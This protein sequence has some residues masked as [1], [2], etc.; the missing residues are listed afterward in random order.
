MNPEQLAYWYWL[1][2]VKG[3]GPIISKKLIDQF[4]TPKEVFQADKNTLLSM[5]TIKSNIIENLNNSK[6]YF[7]KYIAI[8]EKQLNIAAAING[9]ILTSIDPP[10]SDIYRQCHE[11]AV[12]PSI[13]HALGNIDCLSLRKFA[14]VGTRNPTIEG[15]E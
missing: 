11:D 1:N 5:T 15:K 8:A 7:S 10:Y 4:H 14:I 6:S 3:I 13:I 12:L 2:D 9:H